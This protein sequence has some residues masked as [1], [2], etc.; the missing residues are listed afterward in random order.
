MESVTVINTRVFMVYKTSRE[1]VYRSNRQS[2]RYERSMYWLELNN[3][4]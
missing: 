4:H 1:E 3:I 2:V